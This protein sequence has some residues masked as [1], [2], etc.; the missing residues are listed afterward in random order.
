MTAAA[1]EILVILLL[2]LLNG[3]FAMSELA[4][5]SARKARLQQMAQRGNVGAR[6]ALALAGEPN[7]FFPTIQIGIT[8]VGI[9]AGVFGGAT[10]G[11]RLAGGLGEISWLAP[12]SRP[13]GF[14]IVVV[15]ITYLSLVIGEL[16]PKQI[17]LRHAERISSFV[18]IPIWVLSTVAYPVVRLLGVSTDILLRLLG[19]EHSREPAVT[20][21]EIS[22]LMREGAS[23]GVFEQ[24]EYE[25]VRRVFSLGD[26][27]VS[28]LMT[29]RLDS[30]WLDVEDSDAENLRKIMESGY[31]SFPVARG[32]LDNI[33]GIV[34]VEVLLKPVVSGGPFDLKA[35]LETPVFVPESLEV[36]RLLELFRQS[37]ET[38]AVVTSEYGGIEGLVTLKDILEALV[39]ELPSEREGES[40][41]PKAVQE[42]ERSWL[43]DG[44]LPIEEFKS[45]FN[46]DELP[47]EEEGRFDTLAGFVVTHMGRIPSVPERFEWNGM[48]FEVIDLDGKRVDKIRVITSSRYEDSLI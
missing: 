9:L 26:R 35:S 31:S 13:L 40:D 17:A 18:A 22:I 39:G 8:L 7:R 4:I 24:A 19:I 5:V 33:V 32:S 20:E 34:H 2:L 29:P 25:I 30:V 42:D 14:G 41:E 23:S 21:E 37:R 1:F 10:I 48:V 27:R 28:T 16:A 47:G 6:R 45:I 12:Y 46:L 11:E 3:L 44:L 36:F 15:A 38:I 43:V